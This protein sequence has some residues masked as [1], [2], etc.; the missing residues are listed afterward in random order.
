[1]EN[2]LNIISVNGNKM[3]PEIIVDKSKPF[4]IRVDEIIELKRKLAVINKHL[5]ENIVFLDDQNKPL[6]ISK[7]AIEEFKYTG[8]NNVDFIMTGWF[9]DF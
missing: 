4:E 9:K 3:L 8:L 1:M 7:E 5:L 6:E 2:S